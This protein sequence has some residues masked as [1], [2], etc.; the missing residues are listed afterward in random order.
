MRRN[1]VSG[2]LTLALL[3]TAAVAFLGDAEA[4]QFKRLNGTAALP[5]NAQ[6][7]VH[8]SPVNQGAAMEMDTY[9]FLSAPAG[10]R[11]RARIIS[12][13]TGRT[14]NVRFIG[15]NGTIVGSCAAVSFGVC[16]TP[17]FLLAGNLLFQVIVATGNGSPVVA[18]AHYILAIQRLP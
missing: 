15:V 17:S 6:L 12:N 2:I 16:D 10:A 3:L 13:G 11:Y 9:E 7:A 8:A 1:L 4:G 14:L 5:L 18:N